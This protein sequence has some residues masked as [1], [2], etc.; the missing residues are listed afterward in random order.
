MINASTIAQCQQNE[1]TDA[2]SFHGHINGQ[3]TEDNKL[4]MSLYHSLTIFLFRR[5][6]TYKSVL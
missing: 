1:V 4:F 6:K 3:I 2:L 5:K